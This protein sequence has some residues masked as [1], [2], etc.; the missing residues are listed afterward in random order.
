MSLTINN[1]IFFVGENNGDLTNGFNKKK[2][3]HDFINLI[4]NP[5]NSMYYN[6]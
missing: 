2:H 5:S 6:N 4:I 3:F 1:A